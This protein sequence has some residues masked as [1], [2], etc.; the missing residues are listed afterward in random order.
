MSMKNNGACETRQEEIVPAWPP[1]SPAT[2]RKE[3]GGTRD[4]AR[5]LAEALF[6]LDEPWQGRFLDL[7]ANLATNSVWDGRRPTR[8]EVLVWLNA[9]SDLCQEVKLLL[10]AWRRPKQRAPREGQGQAL[11]LP[12]G[13][14][15]GQER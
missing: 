12:T 8:E 10:D 11:P 6:S 1:L 5:S 15:P 7:V 3:Q 4:K 13:V 9:D 2:T 14:A